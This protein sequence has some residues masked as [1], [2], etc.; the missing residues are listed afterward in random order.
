MSP[1]GMGAPFPPPSPVPGEAR[2]WSCSL[3]CSFWL[4]LSGD[5]GVGGSPSAVWTQPSFPKTPAN[6]QRQRGT[7]VVWDFI[8]PL[9]QLMSPNKGNKKLQYRA[10]WLAFHWAGNWG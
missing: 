1:Q 4:P 8:F 7:L 6:K 5:L 9:L 3:C 10:A 2:S